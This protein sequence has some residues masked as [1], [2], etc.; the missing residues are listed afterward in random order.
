[1]DSRKY[2]HFVHDVKKLAN[3]RRHEMK[4]TIDKVL[5]QA[6]IDLEVKAINADNQKKI[7][8]LSKHFDSSRV[9]EGVENYD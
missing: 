9:I 3:D 4:Q 7:A 2:G 8:N 5:T 6:G 1:M